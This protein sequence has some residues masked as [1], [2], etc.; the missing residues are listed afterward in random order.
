[1]LIHCKLINHAKYMSNNCL[2]ILLVNRYSRKLSNR[3]ALRMTNCSYRITRFFLVLL[4]TASNN[5][6]TRGAIRAV[7]A[8]P[9]VVQYATIII[10]CKTITTSCVNRTFLSSNYLTYWN[11]YTLN[12]LFS[13]F[14]VKCDKW[15]ISA[16]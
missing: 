3:V 10:Y 6:T 11:K 13:A 5:I 14:Q 7:L 15:I 1:M 8:R 4:A 12:I 2:L 9:R 16:Y